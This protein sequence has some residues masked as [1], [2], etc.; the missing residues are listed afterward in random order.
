MIKRNILSL[1]ET[2][3]RMGLPIV[4]EKENFVTEVE[5]N[6][7][8]TKPIVSGKTKVKWTY[9]ITESRRGFSVSLSVPD[10]ELDIES[11][12]DDEHGEA[13]P[14]SFKKKI[15]DVEIGGNISLDTD[16][17]P[18]HVEIHKAVVTVNFL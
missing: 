16:I 14:Y 5:F 13:Q 9:S 17:S 12:K 2:C 11:E 3:K 10:Q 8:T 18:S 6:D 15:S 1:N 7:Y 4:E